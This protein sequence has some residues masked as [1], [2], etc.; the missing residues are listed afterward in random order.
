MDKGDVANPLVLH[1]VECHGGS[2]PHFLALVN[3]IES[4][5]LYR[6]VC[7]AVQIAQ[8]PAGPQSLNKCQEWG[9]PWVPVLQVVGGDEDS[10]GPAPNLLP[11]WSKSTLDQNNNGQIKWIKYWDKNSDT[12]K[13]VGPE[14]Q[15]RPRDPEGCQRTL[16]PLSPILRVELM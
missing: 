10:P 1:S 14:S 4:Q 8:M 9:A 11:D 16:Q 13:E 7:E 5:P 2:R 12:I 6:A 15:S 3:A